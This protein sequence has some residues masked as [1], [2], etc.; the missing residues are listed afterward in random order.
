MYLKHF[1]SEASVVNTRLSRRSFLRTG[2]A[3][4]GG[5][6]ISIDTPFLS[7]DRAAA[8]DPALADFAPGAF[9]RIDK[10]GHVTAII[11]PVE[12]GQ[13]VYT[14]MPM[15]I[16]EELELDPNDIRVEPAPPDEKLYANPKIGF[17]A[18]GGSTSIAAYYDPFR[19]AGAVARTMLVM[20]A[21]ATWGVVQSSCR[22]ENGT[23]VHDASKR[24]LTY[25]EL[26]S[27]A[28][29]LPPPEKVALKD[30]S[31]FKVIGRPL[32]GEIPSIR[33]PAAPNTA[34]ISHCRE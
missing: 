21:A 31:D 20:A 11:P 30:P 4:G 19:H 32:S 16:A 6:L 12:I 10:A 33:R 18:T 7:A 28:A 13:G 22:A 2:L 3:V 25:G 17:Q 26:A 29:M 23:V 1:S 27:K 14:S 8:A 24:K 15:L 5:L 34:S 9:I